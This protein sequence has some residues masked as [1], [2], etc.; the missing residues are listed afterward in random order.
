MIKHHLLFVLV[1]TLSLTAC[2]TQATTDTAVRGLNGVDATYTLRP[3]FTPT[4]TMLPTDTPVTAKEPAEDETQ[5][6]VPTAPVTSTV[7]SPPPP[8]AQDRGGAANAPDMPGDG[9]LDAVGQLALGTIHLEETE[10]AVTPQQAV[11]LLP[12]WQAIQDAV[13]QG[14]TQADEDLVQVEGEMSSFQLETIVAMGLTQQDLWTWMQ[15][16][17]I[18]MPAFPGEEMSPDERAT[19][20]PEGTPPEGQNPPPEPMS[21]RQPPGGQAPG[22]GGRRD[23]AG[24]L[25]LLN[26]LIEML[27]TRAAEV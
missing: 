14:Y 1:F 10:S 5:T 16:Q 6:P 19:R 22:E 17:G 7:T 12:L 4:P 13:T 23:G 11:S 20:M 26:A 15:E 2:A 24:Q 21:T 3:T 9:A 18:G 25:A 27:A 8:D